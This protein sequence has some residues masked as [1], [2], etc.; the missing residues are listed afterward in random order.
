MLLVELSLNVVAVGGVGS[1]SVAA[2]FTVI[3][4]SGCEA[5]DVSEGICVPLSTLSVVAAVPIVNISSAVKVDV[6]GISV[7]SFPSG[8][9]GDPDLGRS[10]RKGGVSLVRGR[11]GYNIITGSSV[12]LIPSSLPLAA[13]KASTV[14]SSSAMFS[15]SVV[16]LV[17]VASAVFSVVKME[18]VV[19][20]VLVRPFVEMVDCRLLV[21][22][23]SETCPETAFGEAVD[24]PLWAAAAA[25][26]DATTCSCCCC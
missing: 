2:N 12:T 26:K 23:L 16:S 25:P 5:V 7:V 6:S 4:A 17:F 24:L 19:I 22:N 14:V 13:A 9:T 11:S 3:V 1:V 15:V 18:L 8:M 10:G 20:T 21:L